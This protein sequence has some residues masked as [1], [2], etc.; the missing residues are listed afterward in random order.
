MQIQC[1][2]KKIIFKKFKYFVDRWEYYKAYK[3]VNVCVC[4][5]VHYYPET[6][7]FYLFVIQTRR[8]SRILLQGE[9]GLIKVLYLSTQTNQS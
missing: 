5:I 3:K 8:V 6:S 7:N 4:R 2:N 1:I 9:T